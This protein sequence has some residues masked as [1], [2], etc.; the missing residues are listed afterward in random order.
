MSLWIDPTTKTYIV[1]MTNAVHMGE[2]GSAVSLRTKVATAVA[3]ELALHPAEA[4]KLRLATTTGYNEM[5]SGAR[6]LAVRNGAVKTGIDVLEDTSFAALKPAKDGPPRRIGL[7]TNQT[8]RRRG[9]A[10]DD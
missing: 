2:K 6:K 5:Q 3:V 4:E 8:G 7:L 1:L 10:A 9:G